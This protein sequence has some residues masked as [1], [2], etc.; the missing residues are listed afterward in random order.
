MIETRHGPVVVEGPVRFIGR[1][2]CAR[3]K[4]GDARLARMGVPDD[5]A[6]RGALET[7][8][9]GE[10]GRVHV[11]GIATD[12]AVPELAFHR[13]GGTVPVIRGAVGA[14]VLVSQAT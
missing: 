2:A 6:L 14:P 8:H 12:E 3:V 11:V 13:D 1:N 9:I 5:L 10:A 4:T 7:A